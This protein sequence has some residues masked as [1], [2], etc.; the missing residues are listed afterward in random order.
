MR[1]LSVA[2]K[3][4]LGL[5]LLAVLACVAVWLRWEWRERR[6]NALIEEI[7]PRH[8]VDKFLVKAVIRRESKFDPFAVGK[9][10]EIGLMQVTEGAGRDWAKATG[11]KNFQKNQLFEPRTNIEAGTWYLA[12]AL[13]RW[14]NMD[15]PIPFAL[16]E[17]NA[18][19]S[20]A[21]RWLPRGRQTTADEFMQAI[22]Y[23]TTRR[24][25]VDIREFHEHYKSRGTL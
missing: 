25:I 9:A 13:R 18:G 14:Q 23:P 19:L 3:I 8:G 16:A 1:K 7:A 12:R 2:N 5:V 24:Y 10:G 17:Y 21:Q 4:A 11:R 20:N 22:T 6:W 15:D